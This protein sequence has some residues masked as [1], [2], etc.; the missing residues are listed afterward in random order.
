[1][2]GIFK[3]LLH[4][5][6]FS[7]IIKQNVFCF[8]G[9]PVCWGLLN[10]FNNQ[11]TT[12][13]NNTY[14][15]KH[16]VF[17][18]VRRFNIIFQLSVLVQPFNRYT[19]PFNYFIQSFNVFSFPF[20][21]LI[22]PFNAFSFPFNFFYNRLMFHSI[23]FLTLPKR[24]TFSAIRFNGQPN[25]LKPFTVR[26]KPFTIRFFQPLNGKALVVVFPFQVTYCFYKCF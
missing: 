10:V 21:D 13:K 3:T 23:R 22:Q 20:N 19:L 14:D 9:I 15:Y 8:H 6:E 17:D 16:S 26:L 2:D 18:Y 24:L 5:Q 11:D 25:R 7:L 1:M 4:Y 12:L